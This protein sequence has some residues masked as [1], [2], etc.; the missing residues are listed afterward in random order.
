[1]GKEIEKYALMQNYEIVCIIKN[2]NDWQVHS[3]LL[4][5]IDVAI[6]FSKPEAAEGNI[7]KCFSINKPIV[8]G[9]T[10]W[11]SNFDKIKKQCLSENQALFY[12]SNYSIGVNIF[13]EINRVLAKI[14]NQYNDYEIS[15]DEIHHQEKLDNPSGTALSL[16]RDIIQLVERKKSW[17]NSVNPSSNEFIIRSFR[18]DSVPGIHSITYESDHDIIEITHSAKNRK[19]FAL[20]ALAAAQWLIGKKG[21][22]NMNDLLKF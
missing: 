8:S 12:A 17:T 2:D 10:G 4:K 1:M 20:G 19:G 21:V 22:Y 18:L 16:A 15:L 14:M 5:K 6:E 13:M 9:T 11:L 7:K 3:E